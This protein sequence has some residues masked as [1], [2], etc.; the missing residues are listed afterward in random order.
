MR[1]PLLDRLGAR[2]RA[3]FL[4][5]A[6]SPVAA[7]RARRA[8]TVVT[9]LGGTPASL[10]LATVPRLAGGQIAEAS[11][12]SLITLVLSHILVQI[13]KRTVG[14]P[15]PSVADATA[16]LVTEPDRFSFPS[17]HS[18]AAMAVAFGYGV[19][20]PAIAPL[21]MLFAMV[22]GVSRICLRAHYPSDVLIGQVLAL[23]TGV[24]ILA[25]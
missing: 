2:D 22:V 14:R 10:A 8:W 5:W 6:L 21:L 19:T 24:G 15:R 16:A 18:A 4:R 1:Y 12:L 3:L 23:G 20:F 9:H 17:G 11:R 7:P 13:V 25:L